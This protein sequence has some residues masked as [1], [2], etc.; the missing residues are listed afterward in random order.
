MAVKALPAR[1]VLHQLLS[2]DPETGKLFWKERPVEMFPAKTEARSRC[3]CALWNSRYANAE[4]FTFVDDGYRNGCIAGSRYRAHRVVWK[5]MTG[6]DPDQIDHINGDRE[7]NR[8][9]NLRDVSLAENSRNRRIPK[10]NK[11]GV[12]GVYHWQQDGIEYWVATVG[13]KRALYF[14]EFDE[15]VAA[16]KAAEIEYGFHENHGRAA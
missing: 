12:I 5:M 10:N 15:A 7:D 14:K 13:R 8:F 9:C 3:L 1:D 11:S 2:Y 4:A 16:R 6:D